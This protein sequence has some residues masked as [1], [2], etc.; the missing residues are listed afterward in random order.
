MGNIKEGNEMSLREE[1]KEVIADPDYRIDV[2]VDEIIAKFE[3]RINE[4]IPSIETPPDL[5]ERG[6]YFH[7]GFVTGMKKVKELLK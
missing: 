3:K 6:K 7:Q 2:T 5:D 4:N 1:I